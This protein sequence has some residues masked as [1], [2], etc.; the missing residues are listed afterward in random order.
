[1]LLEILYPVG[2]S[3][4]IGKFGDVFS[5]PSKMSDLRFTNFRENSIA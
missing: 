4:F 3:T 2:N 1:M 5:Y